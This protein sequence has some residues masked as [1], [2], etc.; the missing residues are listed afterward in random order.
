MAQC[1]R[2]P[3]RCI[4]HTCPTL[5]LSASARRPRAALHAHRALR[6]PCLFSIFFPVSIQSIN[7]ACMHKPALLHLHHGLFSPALSHNRSLASSLPRNNNIPPW[8]GSAQV[9]AAFFFLALHC[10]YKP[11]FSSSSLLQFCIHLHIRIPHY[12]AYHPP[13]H[14]A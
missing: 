3:L 5:K 12:L 2:C 9:K 7:Q 4:L 8:L 6:T 10:A 11:I 14:T 13:W 1:T